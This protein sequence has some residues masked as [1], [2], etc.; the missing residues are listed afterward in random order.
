MSKK[1][2]KTK[3]MLKAMLSEMGITFNNTLNKDYKP[4]TPNTEDYRRVWNV[5]DINQNCNKYRWENLPKGLTGWNLERMLYYYGSL[6]GFK[7]NGSVWVLPFTATRDLNAYGFP[8]TIQPITFNG[9]TP[10]NSSND[11]FGADFKVETFLPDDAITDKKACI[12]LDNIP[13][14]CGTFMPMPKWAQNN[15]LINDVVETLK[16]VNI[17][18]VVSNKK[19]VIQCQDEKQA[20]VVRQE[21]AEGFDSDSPFI[22]CTSPASMPNISQASDLQ[23]SDLFNVIKQYDSIRCQMSG[24]L[25][26]SFGQDKKERVNSGELMGEREQVNIVYDTGLYLRELWCEEMNACFGTNIQV[27]ENKDALEDMSD[28]SEDIIEE[29]KENE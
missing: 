27:R 10:D 7:Y 12:L 15:I 6:C 18:I 4:Y 19:L 5:L 16:R 13:E 2:E 29:V 24:I 26:K 28:D 1:Y 21:L 8:T 3:I 11:F 17:N 22:V 25:T 23:A 14:A 20:D 9:R